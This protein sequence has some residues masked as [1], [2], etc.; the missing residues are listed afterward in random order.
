MFKNEVGL[1]A[2]RNPR[3][4]KL[5]DVGMHEPSQDCAL[6]FE[7]LL[8]ATPSQC[9]VEKLHSGVTFEPAIAALGQTLPIPPW[10]IGVRKL[11]API[12]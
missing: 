7:A 5:C 6:A 4:Q 9:D 10:A 8:A 11:Y 1:P 3:I 2:R 12:V